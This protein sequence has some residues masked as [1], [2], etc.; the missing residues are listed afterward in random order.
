MFSTFSMSCTA[1]VITSEGWSW[2]CLRGTNGSGAGVK[3][4]DLNSSDAKMVKD[5]NL[6]ISQ[7]NL[8][9][10]ITSRKRG[11][12]LVSVNCFDTKRNF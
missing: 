5:Y 10:N 8:K 4:H 9:H 7:V 12:S 2:D 1:T 6:K 3:D 11:L